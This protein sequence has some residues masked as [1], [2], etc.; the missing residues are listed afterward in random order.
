MM[1][2]DSIRLLAV[3]LFLAALIIRRSERRIVRALKAAQALSA[4]T[5][6]LPPPLNVLGRWQMRRLQAAGAVVPAGPDRAYFD[7]G[8]YAACR[9]NRRRRALLILPL[10]L[11]LAGLAVWLDRI[12]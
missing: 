6:A 11:A 4:D 9:R 8:A 12:S 1:S 5:A 3:P 7:P 10:L 2:P